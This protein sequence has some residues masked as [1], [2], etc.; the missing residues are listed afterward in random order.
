MSDLTHYRFGGGT[1][2]NVI[3]GDWVRASEAEAEI[4]K[5]KA[6]LA[7]ARI[8]KDRIPD[9]AM[10]QIKAADA[11]ADAVAD[12]RQA[13]M[14]DEY[15][16]QRAVVKAEAAYCHTTQATKGDETP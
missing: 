16:S 10:K 4:R 2:G 11:L 6:Q 9:R 12:W 15:G 7:A 13:G 3:A 14:E 1:G 5:L 8:R